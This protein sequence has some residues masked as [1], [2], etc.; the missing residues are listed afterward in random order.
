MTNSWFIKKRISEEHFITVSKNSKSMAAAAA[1]LGLHFNSFKKRALELGC[2]KPNQAGISIRKQKPKI[3]IADIIHK[4]L[5]PQYQSNKLRIRLLEEGIKSN[6]CE[7]CGITSWNNKTI[8]FELHHINGDKHDH[9]LNNLAL[10][11]P[12]CHS[13]TKNFRSKNRK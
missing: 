3:P 5:H 6:A 12:N 11:C 7:E 9:N 2:Y 4:N 8:S 1:T 13:Q 10:L